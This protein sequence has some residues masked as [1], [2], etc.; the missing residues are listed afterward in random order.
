MQLKK[1]KRRANSGDGPETGQEQQKQPKRATP[2]QRQ[3]QQQQQQLRSRKQERQAPAEEEGIGG[4]NGK[5]PPAQQ[6]Q[7]QQRSTQQQ[8]EARDVRQQE[9]EEERQLAH[10]PPGLQHAHLHQQPA[11]SDLLELL[12]S[13]AAVPAAAACGLN[14]QLAGRFV[15]Q[16]ERLPR[17][18]QA[19]KERRLRLVLAQRQYGIAAELLA[20]TLQPQAGAPQLPQQA[21]QGGQAGQ[22]HEDHQ[23][24]AARSAA[25]SAAG[26]T[27]DLAASHCELLE[28]HPPERQV[29]KE[30]RLRLL[31]AKGL[32]SAAAQLMTTALRLAGAA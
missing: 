32:H 11:H 26:L 31:L 3:Q 20:A 12:L 22:Q 4:A 7:Q 15:A 8:T 29:V 17:E 2:C 30:A 19:V 1:H 25:G 14:S 13:A 9:G 24:E 28:L 18:Q 6:R 5:A 23:Q 21:A 16:L 27:A 10:Q